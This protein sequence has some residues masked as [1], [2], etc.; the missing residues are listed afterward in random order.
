MFIVAVL[1]PSSSHFL[2][3]AGDFASSS[4]RSAAA[5]NLARSSTMTAGSVRQ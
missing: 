5:V 4:A 1:N 2:S 3:K